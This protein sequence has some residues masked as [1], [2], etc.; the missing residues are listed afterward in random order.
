[1][2]VLRVTVLDDYAGVAEGSANWSSLAGKCQITFWRDHITDRAAIIQRLRDSD[3][4]VIERER[5]RFPGWL[6][7]ALPRLKLL[8]ATG[9]VNWSIDYGAAAA[10][11]VV[12]CGT[13]AR[14]DL[15]PEHT[16]ALILALARRVVV[17]DR[18][19]RR[20]VWHSGV[21]TS[22]KD[23]T[24]G[25]IGLG[26]V[27][28]KVAE[29]ARPFGMNIVAYS[30]NLTPDLAAAHGARCVSRDELLSTSDFVSL[31]S[32]LSDR[33]RGMIGQAE[34]KLMKPTAFLINTSRGPLVDENALI[35]ALS[36]NVIAGAAL[37]VFDTEPLPGDHPLI[38]FDNVIITPHIG[39]LTDDQARL[40][41]GQVVENII[42]FLNGK[43]VR[44]LHPP[45]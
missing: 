10:R 25:I 19:V 27:G 12:V 11:G 43:P 15:A 35:D 40:F 38:G 14:Q 36:R 20:G 24:L 22:L 21:G 26:Q 41:Y 28:R 42:A 37:D 33:T 4:A 1:M 17:E 5:T 9:P 30:K 32:V 6:F 3:V 18:A 29:L 31:H 8:V 23:K 45:P 13:Q 16:M 2:T 39:Y 7:E 44:I 34:L